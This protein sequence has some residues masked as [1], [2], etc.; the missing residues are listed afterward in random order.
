MKN[1]TTVQADWVKVLL[2][3][4]VSALSL[5]WLGNSAQA[6]V[7]S[8]F[9]QDGISDLTFVEIQSDDSL[10]WKAALS[11]SSTTVTLGTL[12]ESGDHLAL[13]QWYSSGT[14]LGVVSE[15]DSDDSIVWTVLNPDGNPEQF[16]LGKK[17][18]LV[19][20]GGDFNG[21]GVADAA[22]VRL[23]NG[24]ATWEIVL[25]PL[26]T[27][28]PTEI[29]EVFGKSG[30]RV[31]FARADETDVDWVGVM[32]KTRRGR[33]IAR[34]K[35]VVTG[36]VRRLTRMPRIATRGT[37]PRA[38]AIRQSSGP[39]LL[40]FQVTR[41]SSSR[42][43]VFSMTGARVAQVT[44]AGAGT[45][46]VGDFTAG[47]GFEIAYQSEEESAVINPAAQE[48]TT[49][50]FLGGVAVD[51]INVN[52]VGSAQDDGADGGGNVS[53]CSSVVSWPSSH[54][55]KI[56]GSEHFSESDVRRNTIGIVVRPRGRGPFP[57]CVQAI[58]TSGEVIAQLGLYA[59]GSGWEARYYAGVGCGTSTPLNGAAVARRAR[60]NTGSSRVYMN[61]AGVCYG[62]IDA[63]SCIGSSQC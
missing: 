14:Q 8:D 39:D 12:G 27:E 61:F 23:V 10:V 47:P 11:A 13:A 31:F 40:G 15:S 7:P 28:S 53:Q 18:D 41:G 5:A 51:E 24:K 30:D 58:D 42:I 56:I 34:M 57:S 22:V 36:A 29:E 52:T 33:T 19:L 16:A 46:V 44:L 59:R 35:N 63:G 26:A 20:A 32:R 49:A 37:R 17:G 21:N 4:I 6:A 54:I 60:E 55:Y 43:H 45:A 3:I 9:D 1:I 62:P 48:R 2:L 50:T 38:F 25:D